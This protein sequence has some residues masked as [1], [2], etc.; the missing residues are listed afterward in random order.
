MFMNFQSGIVVFL[1]TFRNES[2]LRHK[3]IEHSVNSLFC[4]VGSTIL[5]LSVQILNENLIG[6]LVSEFQKLLLKLGRIQF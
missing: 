6:L 2:P 1:E 3:L 4:N 5:N